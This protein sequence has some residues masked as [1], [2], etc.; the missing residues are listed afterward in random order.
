M[1]LV[2]R[3]ARKHWRGL[4]GDYAGGTQ[5]DVSPD[6]RESGE[7]SVRYGERQDHRFS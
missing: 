5:T 7:K 3:E 2:R 4:L 6:V 1:A